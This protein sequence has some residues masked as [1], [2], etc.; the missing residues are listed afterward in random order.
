MACRRSALRAS[1]M[2]IEI[3]DILAALKEHGSIRSAAR[4]LGVA[5]SGIRGRLTRLRAR[6]WSPEFDQTH[7][8]PD[9]Q[10]VA[11]VSTLY[12]GDGKVKQQWVKSRADLDQLRA[13]M[14]ECV[15]AMAEDVRGLAKPV[16]APRDALA[17]SLSAYVIGDA[18]FG[19]YAWGEEAGE[20]FDTA[21]AS[22]DLRA[23]IDLL[24]AGAPA[25]A[26]GYLVDVGDFLHAD[27]R[28]PSTPQSGNILDVDTRFQKVIRIAIDAIKYCIGRMLQKHK[29]VRVFIRPGNHNPD[30]AGWMALVIAAYY[31]RDKRVTVETSPAEYV[32]AR[33]GK[34]L[35]GI[36][37][38]DRVK[39][40]QLPAIMA[41]D[42]AKD[43]GET[44]H[45]YWWTGHIHHTRHQEHRGCF[46]ESFNTLAASDA[47]H[48]ASGYRSARQMQRI[49]ID[50]EHGI[51]SRGI[52]NI[53]MLRAA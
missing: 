14:L 34:V 26:I 27:S 11:G 30:A 49:D 4:A 8:V 18:H 38:G 19:L 15:K 52:A 35:I 51:Y 31:E 12:G 13:A 23:A 43:W 2:T 21:I 44:Q 45:R 32:Y 17:R 16:P 42:R 48:H 6:G 33:F 29:S 46:V 28:R 50:T 25:S 39:M 37:H 36:T 47:W 1:A 3:D 40:D 53:G 5:E 20:D 9:G 10:I 7:P 22:R 24:V 41:S